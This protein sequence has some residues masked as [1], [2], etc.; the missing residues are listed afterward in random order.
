[1]IVPMCVASFTGDHQ[2]ISRHLF[3]K[4][5]A[6]VGTDFPA[7]AKL[8]SAVK[9]SASHI[10]EKMKYFCKLKEG[11]CRRKYLLNEFDCTDDEAEAH[12]VACKCCDLCSKK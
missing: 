11:E 12:I 3:K 7:T 4:L 2:R 6:V 9:D 8:F 10:D 1:M 5:V